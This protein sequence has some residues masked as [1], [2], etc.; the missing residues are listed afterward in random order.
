[1]WQN[2]QTQRKIT[3]TKREVTKEINAALKEAQAAINKALAK[4]QAKINKA[5]LKGGYSY[6]NGL[7]KHAAANIVDDFA[8]EGTWYADKLWNEDRKS[9]KLKNEYDNFIAKYCD[10]DKARGRR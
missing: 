8:N 2:Y 10:G 6:D 4:A 3:M 7:P 5:C 1:M 9:A